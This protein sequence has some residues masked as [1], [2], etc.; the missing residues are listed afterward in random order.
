MFVC[1]R[2]WYIL[3]LNYSSPPSSP[4]RS[5]KRS[6]L[7]PSSPLNV[8]I[9]WRIYSVFLLHALHR[10]STRDGLSIRGRLGRALQPTTPTLD[11]GTGVHSVFFLMTVE[12]SCKRTVQ[13]TPTILPMGFNNASFGRSPP[14]VAP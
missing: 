12:G 3:W 6:L 13:S 1:R 2:C 14:P 7:S 11:R 9:R 4:T 10:V 5:A 8:N